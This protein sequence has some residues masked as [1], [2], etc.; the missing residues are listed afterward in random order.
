MTWSS[1]ISLLARSSGT[2]GSSA[3]SS[4]TSSVPGFGGK[5]GGRTVL[6]AA[7]AEPGLR[8]A[9]LWW[10]PGMLLVTGYFVFLYRNFAG[11][12]EVDARGEPGARGL[13][14]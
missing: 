10:V 3:R 13:H 5:R 7:S 6:A 12:I 11:R 8:V 9:L 2:S 1:E 4:R 14:G